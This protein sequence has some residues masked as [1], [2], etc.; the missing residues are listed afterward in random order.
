MKLFGSSVEVWCAEG[1]RPNESN[2]QAD[3]PGNVKSWDQ[4]CAEGSD[5][6]PD[7]YVLGGLG[8][9]V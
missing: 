1:L 6:G 7:N 2:V 9:G 8:F 5:Q 4:G 3:D